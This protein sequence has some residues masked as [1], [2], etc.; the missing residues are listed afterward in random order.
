MHQA[1]T[2]PNG[3]V[4]DLPVRCVPT[5]IREHV[6]QSPGAGVSMIV[7][8]KGFF[9]DHGTVRTVKT[10]L[11]WRERVDLP[12]L[13]LDAYRPRSTPALDQPGIAEMAHGFSIPVIVNAGLIEKS[14]R[15][16][17]G[18][19]GIPVITYEAG[20]ALRLDEG[21]IVSGVRGI[22]NVMRTLHM[23]PS[24]QRKAGRAE[25]SVARS[26]TWFRAPV[27]G[28]FRPTTSFGARVT[29][30]DTLSVISSPFSLEDSDLA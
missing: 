7:R 13:G 21:S 9:V 16:E 20:E 17:A 11:G 25:P 6:Q 1:K 4:H 8:S 2:H 27:D 10:V 19:C 12:D 22:L 24:R 28:M 30:G 14:L 18:K 23:L 15:A 29:R 5:V 26:T 3:I